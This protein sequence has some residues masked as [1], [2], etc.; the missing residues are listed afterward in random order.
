M[1]TTA[2]PYQYRTTTAE[3]MAKRGAFVPCILPVEALFESLPEDGSVE[4]RWRSIG[5]VR[6]VERFGTQRV[7]RSADGRSV[8][9]LRTAWGSLTSLEVIQSYPLGQGRTVR[10]FRH[11]RQNEI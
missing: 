9:V 1:D 3:A 6:G 4:T 2:K 10:T 7:R 5:N 11:A 8:Q